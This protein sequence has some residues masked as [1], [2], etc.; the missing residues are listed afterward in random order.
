MTIIQ[1]LIMGYVL[2]MILGTIGY[3]GE[4]AGEHNCALKYYGMVTK[5]VY[6]NSKMNI[7][8][9]IIVAFMYYIVFPI[10]FI[11]KSI[12]MLV[13]YLFHVGRKGE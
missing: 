2:W 1:I 7:I 5:Y 4:V 13:Y 9:C 8:G 6:E 12:G 10:L 11:P 3:L